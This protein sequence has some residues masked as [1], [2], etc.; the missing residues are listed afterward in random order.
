MTKYMLKNPH[1]DKQTNPGGMEREEELILVKKKQEKMSQDVE[2]L[3][4]C[5]KGQARLKWPSVP[6]VLKN[7][8][9]SHKKIFL[10]VSL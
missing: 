3:P 2:P 4:F 9:I 6:A 8:Q 5:I 1:T 7:F 10:Q